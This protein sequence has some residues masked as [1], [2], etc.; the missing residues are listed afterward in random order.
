M[1]AER[2]ALRLDA[3][4][5]H[6][7]LGAVAVVIRERGRQRGDGHAG[8]DGEGDEAAPRRRAPREL[9]GDGGVEEERRQP[10]VAAV[11]GVDV[12]EDAGADDA[13]AAPDRREIG[14]VEAPAVLAT[15][16][17]QVRHPLRVRAEERAVERRLQLVAPLERGQRLARARAEGGATVKVEERRRLL[18]LALERRQ[19]ARVERG[20]DR[21]ARHAEVG[22]ALHRP[23]ARPLGAADVQQRVDERRAAR[24]PVEPLRA[25]TLDLALEDA[26]RRL[27]VVFA[28][29]RGGHLDEVR[30][31][32]AAVELV[33]E[34]GELRRAEPAHLPAEVRRL[35]NELHHPVLDP[36]VHHLDV[37]AGAARTDVPHARVPPRR[38]LL[39]GRRGRALGGVTNVDPRRRGLFGQGEAAAAERRRGR[40]RGDRLEERAHELPARLRAAGHQAR[41]VARAARAA[42]EPAAEVAEA[43]GAQLALAALRVDVPLV[44]AVDDHV[45]LA[46]HAHQRLDRRVGRLPGGHE[47]QH[48]S[49]ALE[50]A[51]ERP[52]RREGPHAEAGGDGRAA[53]ARALRAVEVEP[54]HRRAELL[55]QVERELR[56]HHTEAHDADLGGGGALTAL[57]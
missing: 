17:L 45:A 41:A 32:V 50:A 26:E 9:A 21:R 27:V 12:V 46:E 28:V 34:V 19:R 3:L 42:R 55:R 6:E 10:R 54:G 23:L 39:G 2:V 11:G 29:E 30:L 22:R 49:R 4:R 53:G 7:H 35:T 18:P 43:G 48:L 57:S 24:A 33:E 14:E 16:R 52:Q 20:L 51:C 47:Q 1:G 15:R 13:A 40:R 37:V 56:A 36:V 8:L 38:R 25:P 44:A 5:R 31:E